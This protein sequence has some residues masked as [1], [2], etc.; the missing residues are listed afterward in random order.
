MAAKDELLAIAEIAVA[1]VG[2]SGLIF[3]VRARNVTDLE[4]RDLSALAMIVSTGSVALAF[5]LLPLPLSY[6]G[7]A[8]PL[9]WRI[10]SGALGA[11][12]LAGAG[13]FHAVNRRLGRAGH[14]ERTPRL[15]RAALVTTF[16]VGALLALSALGVLSSG[17]APYL[18]G[19]VICLLLSL[20]Y[21]GF[22]LVVARRTSPR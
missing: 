14:P 11:T 2:F 8:E 9:F 16:S 15:N 5:A 20:A 19:L 1:L 18:L 21:V 7:L 13:V 17:P 3:V 10:S 6:L 12:M 4:T 22:I